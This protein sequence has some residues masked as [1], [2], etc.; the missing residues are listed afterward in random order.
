MFDK[1]VA[2]AMV[3]TSDLERSMRWYAEKLDLHPIQQIEG[4]GAGYQMGEGTRFFLYLTQFAG[5]AQHTILTFDTRDIH[6][7]MASLR[8]NGVV[9]EEYDFPGLKT[10]NGLADIGPIKNAW[11]K[12]S[13]GNI[14]AIVQ[15][16]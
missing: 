7:D 1:K 12:D 4:A 6:A 9:F 2:T 14:L 13:D 16:M 11:F 8:A 5:T 10:V 3:P 15:G